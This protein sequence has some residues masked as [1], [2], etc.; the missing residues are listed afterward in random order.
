[1]PICGDQDGSESPLIFRCSSLVHSPDVQT[2]QVAGSG[3]VD[4]RF[5]F[6]F[7]EALFNNELGFFKV[8]SPSGAIGTLR[9]G[10]PGYL[11]AA[12]ARAQVIFP[13]GS[14]AFTPDRTFRLNGGDILAFFII[15]PGDAFIPRTTLADLLGSNPNNELNK[16]PLAFFSIDQLNPDSV[17]HFV[18]FQNTTDN[19]SQFGFEDL[20]GGGD[21]DYDDVVYNVRP[22]LL[23]ISKKKVVVFLGGINSHSPTQI[24]DSE[25]VIE[26]FSKIRRKLEESRRVAPVVYFSYSAARDDLLSIFYCNGWGSDGCSGG[27]VGDLRDLGL[28]PVYS[29]DDTHRPVDQHADVLEWLIDQIVKREPLAEIELI[30]YSLGGIVVSRWAAC[31]GGDPAA[32]C[33]KKTTS[34]HLGHIHAIVLIESPV[35]GIPT[36]SAFLDCSTSPF[37]NR[38]ACAIW[39]GRFRELFGPHQLRALQLPEDT[40]GSIVASL[41]RTARLF[42]VTSIQS[43][44]DYLV[45]GM[46]VPYCDPT[47]RLWR[48][49]APVGRGTQSWLDPYT[50]R[51]DQALGGQLATRD[52]RVPWEIKRRIEE[53]HGLPLSH[54]RAA[55]WVSDAVNAP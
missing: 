41:R 49:D 44:N 12:F 24:D 50:R 23:P 17:D 16:R 40:P 48:G 9:P 26:N 28:A 1:M 53:N 8:D 13:S 52:L 55:Q 43:T 10:D 39:G 51:M 2:Y 54:D 14:N 32:N 34:P 4:L 36:A 3:P 35:G 47:C 42:N 30:G 22:P 18:G 33:T 6:V 15:S 31:Y 27:Q 25:P 38:I 46:T 7:R 37:V 5:D 45:N 29:D 21:L 11:V 20:V 19:Y